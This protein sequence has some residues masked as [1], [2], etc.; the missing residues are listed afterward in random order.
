[1]LNLC[2][3]L[4]LH[5]SAATIQHAKKVIAHDT[6]MM[7]IAAAFHKEILSVWGNTVP[8]FG[9]W[10]YYGH[11]PGKNQVFEV[12]GLSCRPCSKLGYGKCPQGHFK[13]MN[14]IPVQKIAAQIA[15]TGLGE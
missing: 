15:G 5:E 14:D 8:A 2:G 13:C 11:R 7:H 1:V 3:K 10:P 9:M 4:S 6:G 12:K